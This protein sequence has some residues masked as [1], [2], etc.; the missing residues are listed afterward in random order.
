VE[1]ISLWFVTA[2]DVVRETVDLKHGIDSI[3]CCFKWN[4]TCGGRLVYLKVVGRK[5]CIV[6]Y[7]NCTCSNH[8]NGSEFIKVLA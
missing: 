2:V 7:Y 8:K 3:M 6:Y 1:V 5:G 4:I